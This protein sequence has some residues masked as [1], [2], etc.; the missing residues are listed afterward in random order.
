M[1][2]QKKIIEAI[3][4]DEIEIYIFFCYDEEKLVFCESGQK[5]LESPLKNNL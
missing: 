1:L 5:L 4:S 3:N 2:S